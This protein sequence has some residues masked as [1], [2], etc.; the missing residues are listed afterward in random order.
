MN[1]TSQIPTLNES[2]PSL[3]GEVVGGKWK[4]ERVLGVGGMAT[5]YYAVHQAT[6]RP[7][8]IKV[9]HQEFVRVEDARQR[10]SL[11]ARV[12]N[13]VNHRGAV[14]VLDDGVL[15]EGAP[16]LVMEFINGQSLQ[17]R[18][19]DAQR[20]LSVGEIFSIAEQLLGIL[21]AAHQAGVL[22]RDVKPDNVYLTSD[23]EVKLLDFGISKMSEESPQNLK[24]QVGS[25]MGTP[26]FMSPEQ[27]RGR[28]DELDP[29]A[30]I[31]AVGATMY[32]V[33]SGSMIHEAET[34]NELLLKVMTR[35]VAELRK[36]APHVPGF[37]ARVVDRAVAFEKKD[38]FASA[39]EMQEA[40]RLAGARMARGS[41]GSLSGEEQV[42]GG[43]SYLRGDSDHSTNR[44]V[45]FSQLTLLTIREGVRYARKKWAMGAVALLM[46]LTAVISYSLVS[47]QPDDEDIS[48]VAAHQAPAVEGPV[49]KAGAAIREESPKSSEGITLSELDEEKPQANR[50]SVDKSSATT[51]DGN[52]PIRLKPSPAWPAPVDTEPTVP[53]VPEQKFEPIEEMDP[54]ARRK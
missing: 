34:S 42:L 21:E 5:V 14:P 23:G 44:P 1:P 4:I 41:F 10:F 54:L 20:R 43:G 32:S 50:D 31:F 8:A 2:S 45:M 9:M 47:S 16:Y 39:G 17:E 18:V 52:D 12:A 22:H 51:G 49:S 38:R 46:L 53:E 48:P 30:D 6:R 3:V 15:P 28:W 26:A 11:E 24:T 35:P 25:T 27:A 36:V 19:E 37:A 33:L 13:R 40:V 7:A 29:R